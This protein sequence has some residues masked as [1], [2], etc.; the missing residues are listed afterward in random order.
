MKDPTFC[1]STLTMVSGP[2]N[3]DVKSVEKFQK[4]INVEYAGCQ[5]RARLIALP[6]KHLSP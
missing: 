2:G 3:L 1:V 4:E 6:I 5:K